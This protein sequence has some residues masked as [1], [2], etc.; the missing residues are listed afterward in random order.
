MKRSGLEGLLVL[1]ALFPLG[2]SMAGGVH[3]L[4]TALTDDGDGDGIADTKETVSLRLTV[5]NLTG[6]ALTG[7]TGRL[8][9]TDDLLACMSV[10]TVD[11]GS[12]AAGEVKVT[13]PFVFAVRGDLDRATLGLSPYDDLSVT[14]D[15]AFTAQSG[16]VAAR[17]PVLSFDLDL[18]VSGGAGPTSFFET[19][20]NTLGAFEIDNM[21]QNLHSL[22]A[23][24]GYRCQTHDPDWVNSNS[25]NFGT[26]PATCFLGITPEHAGAVFWGLSGPTFSPLGGRAFTGVH[27]LFFGVDLGPPKNW[28]TP[29]GVL[30]AARTASPIALGWA[31]AAPVL[32]F[33]HQ[34]SLV[35]DVPGYNGAF[36][37]GVV[38]VQIADDQGDPAGSW[39]KIYPYQNAYVDTLATNVANCLFDPIDDGNTEDDFFHPGDPARL[40]GPSSTCEPD[41]MFAEMGETSNS[42]NAANVGSADGPGLEGQWG[43]GTWIESRFDLGRF[44]GR[45]VRVRFLASALRNNNEQKTW[46]EYFQIHNPDPEDD[47][48]WID[49]VT[50]D[51][52]LTTPAVV[53]AD[54]KDNSALPG[55]PGSDAD[56]DGIHDVC[57]ICPIVASSS[58][59]DADADGLGDAC[60]ACTYEAAGTAEAD[61]DLDKFCE[62]DNCP[63][64]FNPDQWNLDRDPT[65]AACDCNDSE[66]YIYPGAPEHNDTVDNQCPGD[67]G[68][69]VVDELSGLTGFYDPAN[70]N[71]FS[72]PN[73]IGAFDYQVAQAAKA[74][75]SVGCAKFDLPIGQLSYTI[76]GPLPPGQIRFFLVRAVQPNVGSWGQ[77]SSGQARVIPCAP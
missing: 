50:I 76:V 41:P 61:L 31:G 22:A 68:Y 21:D 66:E 25:Y 56:G 29:F 45:Q 43:I 2:H 60:D 75:F 53:V 58:G 23:S 12:L 38:M 9:T 67:P 16:A 64:V 77:R 74:D 55:S 42:F 27:S 13:D 36:D 54:V 37:R 63:V 18:D 49:D 57:D 30:E 5:Q 33:K 8:E 70:K 32:S 3:I 72:W 15:V 28:T 17:P 71:V 19:F 73:Q 46:D 26:I 35:D 1:A 6:G 7:V 69:G 11:I 62:I 4:G 44:R 65:G 24:D 40:R 47:G 52:T 34:I 10:A 51:H 14:F 48:W 20:E 39:I 59:V